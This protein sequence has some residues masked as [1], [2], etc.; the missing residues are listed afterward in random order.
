MIRKQP[1]KYSVPSS[2]KQKKE[3]PFRIIKIGLTRNREELYERINCRV[4]QMVEE[5]LVEEARMVYPHK[6]LKDRKSVV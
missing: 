4:D 3:R 6:S 2:A 5:G 1:Q